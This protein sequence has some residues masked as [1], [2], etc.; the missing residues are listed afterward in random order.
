LSLYRETNMADCTIVPLDLPTTSK[1]I[2]PTVAIAGDGDSFDHK[3]LREYGA[4][5]HVLTGSGWF[6]Y[7]RS[8]S[9][10]SFTQMKNASS[11]AR[12][13]E[14]LTYDLPKLPLGVVAHVNRFFQKVYDEHKAEAIVLLYLDA[15]KGEWAVHCPEQKVSGSTADYDRPKPTDIDPRF[16]LM[17][18]WHSHSSMSPFHSGTDDNDEFASGAG[19]HL[20]SGHFCSLAPHKVSSYGF[21]GSQSSGS[22]EPMSKIVRDQKMRQINASKIMN[23]IE[24][25]AARKRLE[26]EFRQSNLKEKNRTSTKKEG[27]EKLVT[28]EFEPAVV[29]SI[30]SGGTRF[31]IP[32]SD[33]LECDVVEVRKTGFGWRQK[34]DISFVM[35]NLPQVE[36]RPEWIKRV[37]KSYSSSTIG[38]GFTSGNHG[39]MGDTWDDSYG[40]R[41]RGRYMQGDEDKEIEIVADADG[42][43]RMCIEDVREELRAEIG[44]TCLDCDYCTETSVNDVIICGQTQEII[45]GDDIYIAADCSGFLNVDIDAMIDEQMELAMEQDAEGSC[46]DCDFFWASFHAS[47]MPTSKVCR[48]F[49]EVPYSDDMVK[50]DDALNE[51]PCDNFCKSGDHLPDLDHVE[52][53]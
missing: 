27:D 32:A 19:L 16:R 49:G 42:Q 37:K 53:N 47:S 17:G 34:E 52:V 38:T 50:I 1:V 21:G 25:K 7:Q 24:K 40:F 43:T 26:T 35:T 45:T 22:S 48:S 30:V 23:K 14:T 31:T 46:H 33:I 2:I 39:H 44:L 41:H 13:D 36:L 18:T 15:D 9:L 6:M 51:F 10:E 29:A 4:L 8:G 11:L 12:V 20:T 5:V 28:P 3:L